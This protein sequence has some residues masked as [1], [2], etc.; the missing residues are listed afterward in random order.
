M[1]LLG[2]LVMDQGRIISAKSVNLLLLLNPTDVYRMFNLTASANVSGFSGMAGLAEAITIRREVLL[3][4]LL[5][6][7][8]LPLAIAAVAFSR[9]EL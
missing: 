1:A 3:G 7:T 8:V 5:A 9:R 6:W 4:A 2:F